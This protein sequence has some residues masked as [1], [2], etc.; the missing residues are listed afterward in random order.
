MEGAFEDSTPIKII[1]SIE[2]D[3]LVQV[4]IE[5]LELVTAEEV[6]SERTTRVHKFSSVSVHTKSWNAKNDQADF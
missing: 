2:N 5:T 3:E 1:R 4:N 6:L